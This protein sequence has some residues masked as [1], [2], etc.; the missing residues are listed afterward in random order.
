MPKWDVM[1][2]GVER[3]IETT[4]EAAAMLVPS[5]ETGFVIFQEGVDVLRQP[6]DG[7]VFMIP[8]KRLVES[9]EAQ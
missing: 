2:Q 5:D 3:L 9:R 6:T 1:F 4:V 8:A 7:I